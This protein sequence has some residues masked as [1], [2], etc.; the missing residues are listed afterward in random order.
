MA[1]KVKKGTP[2]STRIVKKLWKWFVYSLI[3]GV[4]FL[5]SIKLGLWGKLPDTVELENPRTKLASEIYA[6]DGKVLGK[7][8]YQEDRTNSGFDDIPEH[9]KNALVAT[10]DARFYSHSGIDGRALLRA[11][12]KLGRDGGGSTITQQLAKNLFHGLSNRNFAHRL[13][14]K[15]KEWFLAVEIE[16]RYTK[17]EIIL[18]YFNTVPYGNSYGIKSAA[19]RYFNKNTK[20]L[21][22][23]ESA[24]LVGMLRANTRYN[25]V[26][27][28][29]NATWVRNI[30]FGQMAKYDYITDAAADS[31]KKLPLVTDHHFVDH[32]TGGA[33]YF[34]SYLTKW[35]KEWTRTYAAETGVKYNIY[36]DGLKIFTT[37]DSKLQ[38]YAEKSVSAHMAKLQG[39]FWAE[40]KRRKR[41]PWFT[42][43]DKGDVISDPEYPAR[44]IKR[45][46]RYR[47]LKRKYKSNKDSIDFYLNKPVRM[48]LFSWEGDIDTTLSPMDSLK[49]TKQ[50]LH[51]GFM[52][53]E[54]QTGHVKAWVGGINHKHF[55]Y[56][57]VN[58]KATRQ[59]G[60]TFKPLVY[61]RG[62]DDDKLHPCEIESTG[63][64]I[65]EYGNGK[66][67]MPHNSS[68][69]PAEVTFYEGLQKSINTITA[70][71]MKRLG[72]NS[73]DVVKQ[74]AGKM[75]IDDSKFEPYPSICLGTMDVSVFEMVGAYGTFV[76]GGTFVE[77]IFVTRIEDKNGNILEEFTPKRE[78]AIRQQTAYI[79]CKML[80]RVTMSGG[81]ANRIRRN[82][83]L[84][85]NVAIGG[86]TGTTQGNSDGWFM[87]VTPNLVSGCWV[88]AEERNVH[89]RSTALGQ[90]ANMALPIFGKYM[91]QVFADAESN[92][93]RGYFK[94]P[95][96]EMTID[97]N[98]DN[99]TGGKQNNNGED[100]EEDEEPEEPLY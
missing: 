49:Y 12:T 2:W 83:T 26:R 77:P 56:D 61:A 64:V 92:Y 59:V 25:P 44:M 98:C 65:V 40:T 57:H 72:P 94:K 100:G 30:V 74:T 81:T 42:E 60:S 91:Q 22:I 58:K 96:I 97:P 95:D 76:N 31:L 80:E 66:E 17:D 89:F 10:E 21:S 15:L 62:L 48:T 79:I 9:L 45:S 50:I 35:M 51:T 38:E 67:W 20:D 3:L 43:D 46:A 36:D 16:K 78:E 27:N 63:P 32:N 8:F 29:N 24:V 18:M 87:G 33:T 82:Y 85:D 86:K 54:P 11:I 68:K 53:F 69:A 13:N 4:A 70:R 71:V 28:P 39:Q 84:P 37:I 7:M 93:G 5:A 55:Q 23:E 75:G 1:K 34:R 6:G 14:Q 52:S 73:A 99:Y 88:G 90:G 47:S 41:D 19:K